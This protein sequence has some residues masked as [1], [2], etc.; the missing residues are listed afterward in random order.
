M[1][2]ATNADLAQLVAEK[3]FRSDLYYRLNVFP[4][5][6][7]PLRERREDIP[8]LVNSFVHK[9]AR[10]MKRTIEKIPA[11][12]IAALTAYHWPSNIREL[13]NLIE[14][15]VI[16]TR[17]H[18]LEIP[19]AEL[20]SAMKASGEASL[21][22]GEATLEAVDLDHVLRVLRESDW[23]IGGPTGA[24]TRLGLNR[25]TLNNKL[26]KLGISRPR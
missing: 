10:Q 26:H 21:E 1:V 7:P 8:L 3:K 20:K 4:L 25:T 9:F 6:M 15:G 14:R 24:A 19:L 18:V 23:V 16:L 5:A 2:A 11:E 22:N 13:Q 17:G 12:A